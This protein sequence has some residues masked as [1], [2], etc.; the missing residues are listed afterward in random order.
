MRPES[1]DLEDARVSTLLAGILHCSPHGL[2]RPGHPTT[3]EQ[4]ARERQEAAADQQWEEARHR[5]RLRQMADGGL[6]S[7]DDD[8][9]WPGEWRLESFEP[10]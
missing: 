4:W 7:E 3:G 10:P 1:P 5:A 6:S 2:P 9:G 8:K